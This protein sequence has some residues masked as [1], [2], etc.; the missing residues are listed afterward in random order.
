MPTEVLWRPVEYNF[1]KEMDYFLLINKSD[2]SNVL[3]VEISLPR[4]QSPL[5]LFPLNVLTE[6]WK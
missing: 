1:F 3:H 5:E 4:S 6:E 2:A